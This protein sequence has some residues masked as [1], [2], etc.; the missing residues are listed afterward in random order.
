MMAEKT[1][2]F[3]A[4][5]PKGAIHLQRFSWM[6]AGSSHIVQFREMDRINLDFQMQNGSV[7]NMVFPRQL[8]TSYCILRRMGY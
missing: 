1:F 3:P 2:S 7:G 8:A 5:I 6:L 4:A